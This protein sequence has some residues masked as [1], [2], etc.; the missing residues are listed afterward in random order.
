[1]DHGRLGLGLNTIVMGKGAAG[2]SRGGVRA[3]NEPPRKQRGNGHPV[4]GNEL[5]S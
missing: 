2:G 1:M 5:K 4:I 3:E